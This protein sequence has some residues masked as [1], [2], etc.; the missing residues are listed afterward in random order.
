MLLLIND[1]LGEPYPFDNTKNI[2]DDNTS[3]YP[4]AG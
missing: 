2:I 3:T 1:V 4:D